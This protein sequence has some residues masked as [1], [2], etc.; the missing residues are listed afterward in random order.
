MHNNGGGGNHNDPL[1]VLFLLPGTAQKHPWLVSME[2]NN[3]TWLTVTAKA[4][5]G[6][7]FVT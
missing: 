6:F 4:G 3:Q 7:R 1:S 5:E 2:S